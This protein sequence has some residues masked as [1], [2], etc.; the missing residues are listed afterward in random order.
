M[1]SAY[2]AHEG[3]DAWNGGWVHGREV[4]LDHARRLQVVPPENCIAEGPSVPGISEGPKAALHHVLSGE[5]IRSCALSGR[6]GFL[7]WL[8]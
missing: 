6:F 7:K 5:E 8:Q 3:D 1:K 4:Q 2:L